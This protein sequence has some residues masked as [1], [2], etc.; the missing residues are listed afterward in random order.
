[1]VVINACLIKILLYLEPQSIINSVYEYIKKK[2][3][4]V[5]TY[6]S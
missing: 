4:K 1:M 3:N 2:T 6:T 5:I